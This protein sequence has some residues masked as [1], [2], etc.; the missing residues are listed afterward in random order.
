[1]FKIIKYPEIILRKTAKI[2]TSFDIELKETSIEMYNIMQK[3]GGIGLAG[4]QIN[5]NKRI[6]IIGDLNNKDY[7]VYVNPEIT[8]FSND[9]E[10]SE[11][12]CLSLPN[13]FGLVKRSKK[14]HLKYRDLE[15]NKIKEKLKGLKSVVIQHE[16]D[17]LNGILFIDR[18][19]EITKGKEKL[20]ELKYK[21]ENNV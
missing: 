12:G 6:V 17:H 9:K 20:K 21:L 7:S 3:L 18:V 14:I 19:E 8:Y 16:I 4:P 11:E 2:V 10:I 13:I 5:F 1:M 15:G